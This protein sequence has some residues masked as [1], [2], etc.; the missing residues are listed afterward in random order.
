MPSKLSSNNRG[1][2]GMGSWGEDVRGKKK[3]E[4]ER[5][6]K[7]EERSRK[8]EERRREERDETLEPIET[9]LTDHANQIISHIISNEIKRIQTNSNEFKRIQTNS[10]KFKQIQ[11]NSKRNHIPNQ[12]P[13]QNPTKTQPTTPIKTQTWIVFG[14]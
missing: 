8:K 5:S 11:T 14:G 2:D 9:N 7:D 1:A 6:R 4:A 10:N 13:N 12:I 3:K